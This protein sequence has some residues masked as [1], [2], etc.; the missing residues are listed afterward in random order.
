MS[1][2][3]EL[4]GADQ[5]TMTEAGEN[6]E[7]A[8]HA[9]E[10]FRN[11]SLGSNP[12]AWG[13]KAAVTDLRILLA[14]KVDEVDF[15]EPGWKRIKKDCHF[16]TFTTARPSPTPGCCALRTLWHAGRQTP[17]DFHHTNIGQRTA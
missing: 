7:A 11:K 6:Y 14:A 9:R 13:E 16:P 17:T 8:R 12:M 3:L 2:Q 1:R 4:V 10:D 5:V 15:L